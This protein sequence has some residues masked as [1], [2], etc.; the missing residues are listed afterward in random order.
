ME[1]LFCQFGEYADWASAHPLFLA[2]FNIILAVLWISLGTDVANIF[3]SILTAEIVLIGA[4]AAR[5]GNKAIHAKLDELISASDARDELA[6]VEDR[7]ERDIDSL[8]V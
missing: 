8:R 7:S 1:A 6:H 2:V 4:G 3:I 5:R